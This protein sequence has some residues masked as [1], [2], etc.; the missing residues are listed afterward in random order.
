[1]AMPSATAPFGPKT[2]QD[3]RRFFGQAPTP[4]VSLPKLAS[5]WG[6]SGFYVKDESK[7]LGQQ[8][9]KVYGATYAMAKWIARHI[10]ISIEEVDGL[11]DL[12]KRY[13]DK[14]GEKQVTFVTCTDG[15]HGRAVAY[16]AKQLGQ[17]AVVYMPKGSADARVEHIRA[18]GGD[19]SVTDLNYDDTVELA[20]KK[21]EENGW[22]YLQDTTAP[23]YVEIPTWIMQGYTAMIDESMEQIKEQEDAAPT[24][25]LLQVGVGSMAG[26]VLGYLVERQRLVGGPRPVSMTLEPKNAACVFESAKRGD[27]K[28]A[29]VEGDLETM[30]AGL[31]CGV[32]CDIG[33]DIL[34][35]NVDGGYFWIEDGMAGN[36]MRLLAKHD[37]EAG[38]CGGAGA[39]FIQRL[40]DPS[41]TK[42]KKVREQLGLGKDSRVLI[43]NTEGATDPINYQKQLELP[44]IPLDQLNFEFQGPLPGVLKRNRADSVDDSEAKRA[45]Q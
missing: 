28:I 9:F 17:K 32:P 2:A 10:G 37:L 3:V 39:G 31:A 45:R 7:R 41:C 38:E 23:G 35:Q 34:S 12:R 44:D 33:W 29:T 25:V 22:T 16:S 20:A 40:M 18:H 15:N 24:H 36:G 43:L 13:A 11:A 5:A 21:A 4:L 14:C 8:A 42:A 27:G 30:I 6:L 26:A 19:C 1:M